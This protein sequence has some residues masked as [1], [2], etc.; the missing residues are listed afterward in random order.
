MCSFS[1]ARMS[2][3]VVSNGGIRFLSWDT[4]KRLYWGI[5]VVT[6]QVRSV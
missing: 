2:G 3:S 1:D 6:R 4:F 5:I